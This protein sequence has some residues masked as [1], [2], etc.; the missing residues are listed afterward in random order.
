MIRKEFDFVRCT[1]MFFFYPFFADQ[2][3]K[4]S[5]LSRMRFSHLKPAWLII[6]AL[7]FQA[8]VRHSILD[9]KRLA[10]EYFDS[11]AAWYLD[12]I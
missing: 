1:V 10:K 7:L 6:V 11:D 9:E 5:C 3:T 4:S 8:C 12:N 2:Q